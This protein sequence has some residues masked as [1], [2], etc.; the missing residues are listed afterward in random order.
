MVKNIIISNNKNIFL[1]HH[2]I[3]RRDRERLHKHRSMV[4]WFTGLSGSGKSTLA[5]ALEQTLY[6]DLVSTYLLDGDNIRHGLCN[7]LGFSNFDRCEHMR[8]VGELSK[9]MF[10]AGLVVLSA[11]ISPY[12]IERQLIRNKFPVGSFI[13]I[14]VDTPLAV[15]RNRDPKGLYKKFSDGSIENFTGIDGIYEEP[16]HPDIH[17]D[18]C[19]LI[20]HLVDSILSEINRYL[21]RK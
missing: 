13:E 15:C 4:L 5:N 6:D 8:R 7:D 12:R 14:F 21:F 1:H 18:G 17:L 16:L 11:L 20:V 3:Q 19:E 10:D 2:Y 9:L